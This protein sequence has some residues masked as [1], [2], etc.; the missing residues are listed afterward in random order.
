MSSYGDLGGVGGCFWGEKTKLLEYFFKKSTKFSIDRD[1]SIKRL[2]KLGAVCKDIST[3][4]Y[5]VMTT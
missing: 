5:P 3:Y 1:G 4:L 2:S